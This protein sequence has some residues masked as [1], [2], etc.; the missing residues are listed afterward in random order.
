MNRT[1]ECLDVDYWAPVAGAVAKGIILFGGA[2]LMLVAIYNVINPRSTLW[3]WCKKIKEAIKEATQPKE[4]RNKQIEV[5]VNMR[6]MMEC[7]FLVPAGSPIDATP[8]TEQTLKQYMGM[9]LIREL[10]EYYG[11]IKNLRKIVDGWQKDIK[12]GRKNL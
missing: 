8:I 5:R 6:L 1:C 4:E 11:S 12:E 7:G 2:F 9:R 3:Q 10:L